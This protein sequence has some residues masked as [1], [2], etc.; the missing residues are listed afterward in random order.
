MI[1]TEGREE[2]QFCRPWGH[3][4]DKMGRIY[5]ADRSNNRIQ[6]FKET[7]EFSHTFGSYGTGPGQFDRPAGICIDPQDRVIVVDKDNHRVQV[8]NHFLIFFLL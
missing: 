7:G 2:G 5:V 3:C 8:R 1:G 6:V 4:C